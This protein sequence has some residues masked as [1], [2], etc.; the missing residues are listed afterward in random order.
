MKFLVDRCVGRRLAEW[1]SQRG[2]DVVEARTLGPDSGDSELLKWA[3]G[4]K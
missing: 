4:Q 1:L 2:H 3:V